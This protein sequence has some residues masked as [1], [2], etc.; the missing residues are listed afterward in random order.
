[1]EHGYFLGNFRS[2]ERGPRSPVNR[3][4]DVVRDRL[5][6]IREA[7]EQAGSQ[8][9]IVMV[10]APVQVCGAEHF[11]YYPAHVDLRDRARFDLDQPQRL[12]GELARELD[13][14]FVD[15]RDVLQQT[16]VC[17]YQSRNMHWTAAGHE[18]VAR[19]L[20]S[21]IVSDGYMSKAVDKGTTSP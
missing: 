19:W 2:L 21:R 15:L 17:A 12:A 20:A 18:V 1:D 9:M 11:A 8:V 7:A 5:R 16:P 4:R 6:E 3:A 14:E 10:P 13:V